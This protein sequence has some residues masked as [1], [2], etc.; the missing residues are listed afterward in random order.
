MAE[1][2][3]P[4]KSLPHFHVLLSQ[5]TKPLDPPTAHPPMNA[6]S[7]P[8]KPRQV[9]TTL[10]LLVCTTIIVLICTSCTTSP[11]AKQAR[12]YE[13][14]GDYGAAYTSITEALRASPKSKKLMESKA[15]IE[16]LYAQELYQAA[17]GLKTNDIVGKIG[18]L[19]RASRLQSVYQA[20]I[21][22]SLND[23]QQQRNQLLTRA[24]SLIRDADLQQIVSETESMFVYTATDRELKAKLITNSQ[25]ISHVAGLLA[26]EVE[27]GELLTARQLGLQCASLWNTPEIREQLTSAETKL[28]ER[29]LKEITPTEPANASFGNQVV[30]C[31]VSVL[32]APDGLGQR[33]AYREASQRLRKAFLPVAKIHV[34][35]ALSDRQKAAMLSAILGASA[36][37]DLR[38]VTAASTNI[39]DL[40]ILIDATDAAYKVER[41]PRQVFSK[42]LA[43]K[44]QVPNPYYDAMYVQYQQA[45]ANSQNATAAYAANPNLFSGIMAGTAGKR[46]NQMANSLSSIPRYKDVPVYEDYQLAKFDLT[47]ECRFE[48]RSKVFDGLSGQLLRTGAFKGAEEFQFEE[49]VGAHPNDINGHVDKTAQEGWADTCLQVYIDTQLERA[50]RKGTQLYDE[51]VLGRSVDAASQGQTQL[52]VEMGLAWAMNTQKCTSLGDGRIDSWL[53]SGTMRDLKQQFDN[54]CFGSGGS[55]LE[56]LW[57]AAVREAMSQLA[58]V[59]KPSSQSVADLFLRTDPMELRF[60][61]TPIEHP[62]EDISSRLIAGEHRSSPRTVRSD[63]S[64]GRAL[65]STVTVATDKGTG[66]GFVVSASG[67]IVSNHHVIEDAR[68]V[69]IASAEGRKTYAEVVDVNASR[70]LAILKATDGN[71]NPLPLGNM[72]AIHVGDIVYALGSPSGVRDEVL[73]QTVTRGVISSI[74]DRPSKLNPNIKVEFIQTDAAINPGNSGGPLIN[75]AGEVIGVNTLKVVGQ[76]IEGLG[77]SVSIDEVKKLFFRYL[78]N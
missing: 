76:D 47:V 33:K 51:I 61:N 71:W 46:A 40:V 27:Q 60:L 2:S 75:E 13:A 41:I 16:N 56:G 11:A 26:E 18:F 78:G 42:Y 21:L 44:K 6:Y 57:V 49:T 3:T 63:T 12:L 7:S 35:G 29:G 74:R 5:N 25:L 9:D 70:D 45:L 20:D 10:G 38:F 58:E 34:Q 1:S 17:T 43:G 59:A 19:E 15:R 28:R 66:S 53:E 48:A 52:A 65:A 77:F 39:P 8:R 24:G 37:A 62:T 73:D 68:R 4:E 23:L 55:S 67:Y 31:L 69:M 30:R 72:D 36:Q 64:V 14:Q 50:A 32:F 54:A 22:A